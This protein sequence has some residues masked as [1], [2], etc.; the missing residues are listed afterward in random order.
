MRLIRALFIR[1]VQRRTRR[2]VPASAKSSMAYSDG[3]TRSIRRSRGIIF[4]VGYLFFKADWH[5]FRPASIFI[6]ANN[7]FASQHR[8][9]RQLFYF[10]SQP[11]YHQVGHSSSLGWEPL[12]SF[13]VGLCFIL[14]GTFQPTYLFCLT[15]FAWLTFSMSRHFTYPTINMSAT[16]TPSHDFCYVGMSFSFS[17]S[18]SDLILSLDRHRPSYFTR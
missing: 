12:F 5:N 9:C 8:I 17:I 18:F 1:S 10:F 13:Y 15:F 14:A 11:T 16:S 2:R 4:Y 3:L 6:P 7:L